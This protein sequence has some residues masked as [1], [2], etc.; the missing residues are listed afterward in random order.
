L[1]DAV[2][3]VM[4]EGYI[5]GQQSKTRPS[6]GAEASSKAWCQ[7]CAGTEHWQ[8]NMKDDESEKIVIVVIV[9]VSRY[10]APMRCGK[11]AQT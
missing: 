2:V 10:N 7:Y 1:Q 6:E 5:A 3:I 8:V 4:G 9:S 11:D